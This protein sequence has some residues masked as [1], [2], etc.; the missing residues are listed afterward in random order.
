MEIAQ[1]THIYIENT[2]QQDNKMLTGQVYAVEIYATET[3][4]FEIMRKSTN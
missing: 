4:Q 3:V 2:T 1:Y